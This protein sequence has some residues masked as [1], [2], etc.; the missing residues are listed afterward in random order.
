MSGVADWLV[1]T[2]WTLSPVAWFASAAAFHLVM[3]R[4]AK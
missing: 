4:V 1:D 2:T 3:R